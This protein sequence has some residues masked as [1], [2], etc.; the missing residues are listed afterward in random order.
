VVRKELLSAN[1]GVTLFTPASF[2]KR[3]YSNAIDFI[4]PLLV[5]LYGIINPYF[6]FVD[7]EMICF[8]LC[9]GFLLAS[10]MWYVSMRRFGNTW[11]RGWVGIRIIDA[12]GNT[13][14]LCRLALRELLKLISLFTPLIIGFFWIIWD[15]QK[16]SWYDKVTKTYVVTYSEEE[17]NKGEKEL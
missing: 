12:H 2:W 8:M 11:G 3:A 10:G 9:I 17:T 5:A 1:C 6:A 16:Q 4:G 13:P 15:K 7:K 14:G